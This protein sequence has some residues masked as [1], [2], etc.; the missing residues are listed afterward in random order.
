MI[1]CQNSTDT[2][3]KWLTMCWEIYVLNRFLKSLS[4]FVFISFLFAL[5]LK[6]IEKK[7]WFDLRFQFYES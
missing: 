6:K 2:S 4:E 3:V 7:I 5:K 1:I